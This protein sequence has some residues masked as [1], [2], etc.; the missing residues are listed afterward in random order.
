LALVASSAIAA[1]N[2]VTGASDLQVAGEVGTGSF[3]GG[4]KDSAG[5]ETSLPADEAGTRTE[6]G[7]DGGG[8]ADGGC[9]ATSATALLGVATTVSTY[10]QLTPETNALAGGLASPS[11]LTLDDF[12]ASFSYSMTYSNGTNPGAGLAFFVIAASV[13]SLPCQPSQNL[14]TLGGAKPG[15]AVILR[16]SKLVA[17]DPEVPYVAVVDSQAFP[18]TQ[19]ADTVRIDPATAYALAVPN[20]G[21]LPAPSTF[22]QMAIAVRG[23]TINVSIDGNSLMKGAPIP[24]WAPGRVSTWGIGSATGLGSTFAERTVV[25]QISLNR[26]PPP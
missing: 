26:C 13:Q 14:C 9:A 11:M 12:D 19:P 18:S 23:G 8:D 5:G 10:W 22:H 2:L 24:N 1:C 25:G 4:R 6:G 3:E 7:V 16:T 21:A 17:S 15:F 20:P